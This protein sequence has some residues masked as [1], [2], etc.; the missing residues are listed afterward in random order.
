M[1]YDYE[2]SLEGLPIFILRNFQIPS[3]N[4]QLKW[5]DRVS[6][7]KITKCLVLYIIFACHVQAGVALLKERHDVWIIM[8]LKEHFNSQKFSIFRVYYLLSFIFIPI[9]FFKINFYLVHF[10]LKYIY[11]YALIYPGTADLTPWSPLDNPKNLL[12]SADSNNA[13]VRLQTKLQKYETVAAL[14]TF[15]TCASVFPGCW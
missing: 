10:V 15:C 8:P 13:E 4:C 5:N 6:C 2:G 9:S 14:L 1:L 11:S 7:M 12:L 3:E